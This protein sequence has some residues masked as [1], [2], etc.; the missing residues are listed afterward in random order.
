MYSLFTDA[1]IIGGCGDLCELLN[2]KVPSEVLEVVCNMLCDVVG[3]EAF[4]D[5]IQKYGQ[6][7][8]QV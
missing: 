2:E 4:V 6:A 5:L 3:V 1:G 8:L 7:T